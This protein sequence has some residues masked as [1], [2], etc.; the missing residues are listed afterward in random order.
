MLVWACIVRA[1]ASVELSEPRSCVL[2]RKTLLHHLASTM[3][4]EGIIRQSST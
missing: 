4:Y 2:N 3:Q 1:M